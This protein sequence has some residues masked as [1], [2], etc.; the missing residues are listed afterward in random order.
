MAPLGGGINSAPLTAAGSSRHFNGRRGK[1]LLRE[2]T[3]SS[4][5]GK[6][7]DGAGR[8][9]LKDVLHRQHAETPSK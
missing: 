7:S 9:L 4:S 2:A 1:I 6:T 5:A 3:D 8:G